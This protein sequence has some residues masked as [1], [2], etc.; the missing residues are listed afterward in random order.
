MNVG[1]VLIFAGI[2]LV[3]AGLIVVA[4]QHVGIRLGALPGDIRVRGRRGT[5]YFPVV[6]CLILSAVLSL[7][8]WLLNRR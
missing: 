1:R 3:A 4:A 7:V 2:V 8:M 5:F 6:T